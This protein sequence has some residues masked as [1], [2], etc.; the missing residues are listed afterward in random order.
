[1]WGSEKT[2]LSH[3]L[4]PVYVTAVE[5]VWLDP[6]FLGKSA[7]LVITLSSGTGTDVEG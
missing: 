6:C 5:F 1:M 7:W 4:S 2:A 3:L